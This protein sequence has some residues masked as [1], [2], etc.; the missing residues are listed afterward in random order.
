MIFFHVI[1]IVKK[2]LFNNRKKSYVISIGKLQL[3][4]ACPSVAVI[5]CYVFEGDI[6]VIF[7]RGRHI[8]LV[9]F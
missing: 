5:Y 7:G 4:V 1:N 9:M 6:T 3:K 2:G 8:A